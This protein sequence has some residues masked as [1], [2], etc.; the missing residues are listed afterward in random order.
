M[1]AQSFI[2]TYDPKNFFNYTTDEVR[3]HDGNAPTLRECVKMYG[4]NT[5]AQV[6]RPYLDF[7]FGFLTAAKKP[8]PS[9]RD[10]I[11]WL[12][13]QQYGWLKISEWLLFFTKAM[14]G[15]FGKF[16]NNVDPLDMMTAIREWALTCRDLANARHER[17]IREQ[18]ERERDAQPI[19]EEERAHALE[20][21]GKLYDRFATKGKEVRK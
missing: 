5:T 3:C 9:Q 8:T 19:T 4:R 17:S 12:T 6:M 14:A 20:V 18:R 15:E 21:I 7:F 16:Y 11:V 10:T 13:I 2:E 1:S